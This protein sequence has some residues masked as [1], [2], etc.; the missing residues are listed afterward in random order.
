MSKILVPID[1]STTSAFA[2]RYACYLADVTGFDLEAAHVHDGYDG[3]E[4][5][6]VKKG[7]ARIRSRVKERLERFVSK[8][9][10]AFT[11]TGTHLSDGETPL[12]NCREVVGQ[13][14]TQLV[15]LS[16]GE[17]VKLIVM[18]GVGAGLPNE[19]RPLF[20]S[21]AKRVAAK[22]ACPVLLI[23]T[24]YG[25]PTIATAA[26]AFDD[27]PTLVTISNK[28]A[29]LR[30]ALRPVM[31]FTHV[32][33]NEEES[34]KIIEADLESERLKAAFPDYAADVDLLPGGDVPDRLMEYSFEEKID[35]IILGRHARGFF[36]SIVFDSEVPKM[37]KSCDVPLLVVPLHD[38]WSVDLSGKQV[39]VE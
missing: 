39:R 6:V 14:V 21:V 1:F 36:A 34:R 31:K 7:S 10:D 17:D 27:V 15:K 19:A 4:A 32:L 29:F 5:F 18:G 3:D 16:K 25:V 2:L 33:Y 38:S 13:A 30:K 26:I 23:P 24:N 8:H 20:G 9:A 35:L 28:T 11:F 37:I 12:I 22:A